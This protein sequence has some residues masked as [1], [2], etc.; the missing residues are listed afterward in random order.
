LN[1]IADHQIIQ[2][3]SNHI[4]KGLI[5]LERLFDGNDVAVKGRVSGD[6]ADTAE[7]NIGTPEEPKFVKLSKSLTEEQRA[8]YTKLL[9]E[10]ADVFAWT[11]EDLKTYD[12]SVIEHKIPLKEEARPFKQKLRQ[13]N[14]MLLPVMER[15]VKKLL[16]A[17]IIVPLRYSDWV[18]NLVP[19]RK[20]SG[21]IRLCVDFRNLNR[22]SRKD[23]YPL[24]NME[25]ILQKVTGA[26]RISMIDGFL[27]T[28]RYQSCLRTEKR[29]PSP[30]LGA[31][32]CM[33]RCLWD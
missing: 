4:P 3:P 19:V 6:D 10:F 21:E 23:N 2:L 22:S 11:Y 24:P 12:T 7:C 25:H 26:S 5:P 16:D 29:Q 27:A 14:P 30:L 9:R 13:I 15:E 20:K 17:Q 33:P 8:E 28:I 31:H 1:K 32:S 18:A